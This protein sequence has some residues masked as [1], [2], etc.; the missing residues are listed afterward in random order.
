MSDFNTNWRRLQELK[1]RPFADAIYKSIWGDV[2]VL[3]NDEP[4]KLILDI[5]YAID[6]I[7]KL[8]NGQQF[9]GQEKF[10]SHNYSSFNTITVEYMNDWKNNIP[11]DWFKMA[12]QFYF[13]SYFNKD[14]TGFE[15]WILIDWLKITDYT[16]RVKDNWKENENKSDNAK[17]SFKFMN[18]TDVPESCT[19]ARFTGTNYTQSRINFS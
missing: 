19:I 6:V 14:E 13:C 11:G 9:N 15:K 17:A 1:G 4:N 2:E 16:L 7:I 18:Y 8:P 10:L 3:R 12:S 5:E